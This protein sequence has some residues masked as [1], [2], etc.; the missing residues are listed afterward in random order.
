[1]WGLE[2]YTH[3][4]GFFIGH[5]SS[6]IFKEQM[7][8]V[9]QDKLLKT[10]QGINSPDYDLHHYTDEA[11]WLKH[12]NDPDKDAKTSQV[13]VIHYWGKEGSRQ[14]I[15][16]RLAVFADELHSAATPAV[17]SCLILRDLLDPNLTTMW[18]RLVSS[19]SRK[20]DAEHGRRDLTN[21][22]T[23]H[24]LSLGPRQMNITNLCW[25][26]LYTKP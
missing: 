24:D 25:S 11:G 20:L 18:L 16:Q 23:F 5:P 15:M 12:P 4:I 21:M 19:P 1:M 9:D 26:A 6:D 13:K 17:Q 3:A 14:E 22:L 8:L 10:S 2:G 7:R